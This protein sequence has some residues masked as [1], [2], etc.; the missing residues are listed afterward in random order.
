MD[1]RWTANGPW[2]DEGRLVGSFELLMARNEFEARRSIVS[3]CR[4]I[5][6]P[7]SSVLVSP[8][9]GIFLGGYARALIHIHP[10]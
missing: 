10:P 4:R 3:A 1:C 2:I 7:A 9:A 8:S 6:T 5:R